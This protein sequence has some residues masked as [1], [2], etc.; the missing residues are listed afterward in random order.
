MDSWIEHLHKGLQDTFLNSEEQSKYTYLTYE[1]F[2]NLS[3]IC[4]EENGEALFIITAPKGTT[5][6]V[7]M[8]GSEVS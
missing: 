4:S 6:E 1:D 2:K 7:P 5:M 3:K 8:L